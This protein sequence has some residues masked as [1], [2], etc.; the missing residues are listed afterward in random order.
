MSY[1]T[2]LI[3]G[4]PAKHVHPPGRQP[5]PRH[6]NPIIDNLLLFLIPPQKIIIASSFAAQAII[7]NVHKQGSVRQLIQYTVKRQHRRESNIKQL[8]LLKLNNKIKI[9]FFQIKNTQFSS[10]NFAAVFN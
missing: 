9:Q 6:H 8:L 5:S 3:I 1:L 4:P 10:F 7:T 2:C